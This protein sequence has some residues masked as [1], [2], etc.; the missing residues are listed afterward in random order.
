MSKIQQKISEED[1]LSMLR[2]KSESAFSY[3]YDNY[4]AALHG[5]I[6]RIVGDADRSSDV[7]Q[8]SFVKIWKNIDSYEKGKG[9]LFTWMLNIVR[10]SA[11]DSNRSKHVKYQIQ[12]EERVVDNHNKV[13]MAEHMDLIGLKETVGKLRP[14]YKKLVEFIYMQGFTQQEY[15][16]EFDIPL[17]TVKTRTR[18]ALQELRTLLKDTK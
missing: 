11:I 10:N 8:D 13:D 9:T 4:A 16:D 6:F 3:L 1:L 5:I 2:E 12:M 17:G 18:S 7:L 15:A 14:E